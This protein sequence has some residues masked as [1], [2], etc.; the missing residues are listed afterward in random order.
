VQ[1]RRRRQQQ[2]AASALPRPPLSPAP[3]P[4]LTVRRCLLSRAPPQIDYLASIGLQQDQI[5]NMASIS[6]VLLGLNPETRLATV[7]GRVGGAQALTH[8]AAHRLH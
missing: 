7:R 2:Q 4:P 5:C 8:C 1:Q 3:P 6:V